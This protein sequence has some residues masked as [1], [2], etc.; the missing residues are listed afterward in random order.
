MQPE[1]AIV[2]TI[3][4]AEWERA[5]HARSEPDAEPVFDCFYGNVQLIAA[6][7]PMLGERTY[8]ISVADLACGLAE[9]LRSE[10]PTV[11]SDHAATF[12]Q[13]DDSL[14]LTFERRGEQIHISSNVAGSKATDVNAADFFAGAKEFIERFARELSTRIPAALEWK[15]LSALRGYGDG[16]APRR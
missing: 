16:S 9:I 14:E 2:Y 15:D 8:N 12:R 10:L 1:F 7:T 3:D 6:G 5:V 13:S 11:G 4:D